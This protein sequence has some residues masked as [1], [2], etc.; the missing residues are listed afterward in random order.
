[1]TD[2]ATP[3]LLE[4][5]LLKPVRRP[6][7]WWKWL[8]GIV[9]TL[10]CLL[11][12]AV[13][14]LVLSANRIVRTIARSVI[15]QNTGLP[16]QI[17][18]LRISLRQPGIHVRGFKLT[19]TPEFG[20]ETFL[21]LPELR[22]ELDGQSLREDKVRFKLVRLNLAEIHVV[23]DERGRLNT[24]VIKERTDAANAAKPDRPTKPDEDR[25]F[26]G[27]D[28]FELTLGKLRYTDLR[29]PDAARSFDFGMTNAVIENVKTKEEL[30]AHLITKIL[31]SGVPVFD[32]A[33]GGIGNLPSNEPDSSVRR[34][35]VK[36]SP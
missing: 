17:E 12:V 7:R 16:T 15:E 19:N 27:L 34:P 22:I 30:G 25:E 8:L 20:G 9:A 33:V 32:L 24:Q 29:D 2:F 31:L 4:P 1:M 21:E 35:P 3:P 11:V 26:A 14:V 13:A 23:V 18:D 6:R 10:F 36:S 28:R 5:P